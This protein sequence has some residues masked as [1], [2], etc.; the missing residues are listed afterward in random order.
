VAASDDPNVFMPAMAADAVK[1][2][3]DRGLT[4]DY[5]ADSVRT[6]ESLLGKLHDE[7]V[8]RPMSSEEIQRH[9]FQFGGY[10]GEILRRKYAGTWAKDHPVV[11]PST[12][13]INWN[14][15][16]SFPVGWCGKRILNGDEDNVWI[17]FQTVISK[18]YQ[19]GAAT[20]PV[21]D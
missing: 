13:P 9:A 19:P 5:S 16:S 14:G 21:T 10:I 17:K 18:D 12:F 6:V 7:H 20:R 4:L 15:G 3:A 8:D 2:A 1:F 11:G